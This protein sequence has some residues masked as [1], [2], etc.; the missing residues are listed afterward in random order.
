[1]DNIISALLAL[2]IISFICGMSK[3]KKLLASG[4]VTNFNIMSVRNLSNKNREI[5]KKM[6][7]GFSVLIL[8]ILIMIIIA[9]IYGSIK[10]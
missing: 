3:I 1:M 7:I 5:K 10:G 6:L 2:S 8:S 9:N 4:E